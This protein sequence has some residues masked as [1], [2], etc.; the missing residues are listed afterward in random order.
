MVIVSHWVLRMSTFPTTRHP[1]RSRRT[2]LWMDSNEQLGMKMEKEVKQ[3]T[4]DPMNFITDSMHAMEYYNKIMYRSDCTNQT[5]ITHTLELS[6]RV[7]ST[8][9]IYYYV[10]GQ[11]RDHAKPHQTDGIVVQLRGKKGECHDMKKRSMWMKI[12]CDI[13]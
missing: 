10:H 3:N 6:E 11:K 12:S 9:E 8:H 2:S 1:Y 13:Q 7:Q 5:H 4:F